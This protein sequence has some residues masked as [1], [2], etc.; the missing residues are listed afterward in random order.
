MTKVM[1][2]RGYQ[3]YWNEERE[4]LDPEKRNE[5]ILNRIQKQLDYVYHTLPFYRKHYDNHNF[6]PSDVKTIEDF[7]RKVPIITKKMLVADQLENPT[8]GSYAGPFK[9][10]EI[11]RI[12]GS[13]GTSGTPTFYQV[14]KEDWERAAEIHAM[15]MWSTGLRPDDVIQIGFPFSLFFGGWGVLQGAERIGSTIFPLGAIESDKH[16]DLIERIKPSTFSGT[17]SY[18]MH[19]LMKAKEKGIDL[20]ESSV[21]R[22]IAGGE[23]G[24]SLP[25]TK[26]ILTN[27]WNASLHDAGSTSEMYPFMTSTACESQSGVHLY[28]D[29]VFTEIVS[30]DD[31]HQPIAMGE[32]GAIV[33]T[34]LW[35]QSQPMIRFWPGDESFMTDEPCSCGRTYPRLPHGVLGRLDDM[36]VIRGTNIY[37]SAI[38]NIVRSLSWSSAEYQIIVDKKGALD[39]ML[40]K[41]EYKNERRED[42][43]LQMENEAKEL[44][45]TKLGI[46][47][48][49]ELIEQGSLPET[50]FKARRVVD[51][52][53]TS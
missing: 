23:I 17:V 4:T 50:I 53:K 26:E 35:R 1:D 15:A 29:E 44:F 20:Q 51:N 36:L 22:L 19:L 37:P 41:I 43:R 7:S 13:S 33:Y 48:G 27:G 34:H 3:K 6:K 46:R 2:Q 21:T 45:K 5:I 47:I 10:N 38:E 16:L 32:R 52:R 14:S 18:C 40:V 12:Q 11:A 49:V 25:H 28:Q 30:G 24:A 42:Q 39:E 31:P 8:F 9:S